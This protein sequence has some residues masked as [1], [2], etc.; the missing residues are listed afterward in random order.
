MVLDVSMKK[1]ESRI[2]VYVWELQI[3]NCRELRRFKKIKGIRD[4]VVFVEDWERQ[5][6]SFLGSVVEDQF[7]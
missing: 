4:G 6:N 7:G 3:K 1:V 2:I 5:S